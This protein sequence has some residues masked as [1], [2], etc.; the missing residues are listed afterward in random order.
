MRADERLQPGA[1]TA[2]FPL[3]DA[4]SPAAGAAPPD[5]PRVRV[6]SAV[7][8][9]AFL[10]AKEQATLRALLEPGCRGDE[11]TQAGGIEWLRA[12]IQ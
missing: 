5:A 6:L 2:L 7:A 3:P 9:V 10:A 4:L 12:L 8:R 1:P 11:F